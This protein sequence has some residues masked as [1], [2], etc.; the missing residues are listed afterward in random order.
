VDSGGISYL[1]LAELVVERLLPALP[2]GMQLSVATAAEVEAIR[3]LDPAFH[4]EM[5]VLV[6]S[7]ETG[8]SRRVVQ[9]GPYY[10]APP[11]AFDDVERV[12]IALRDIADEACEETHDYYQSDAEIENGTIR[13]WFG[14]VPHGSPEGPWR[15]VVPELQP[16]PLNSLSG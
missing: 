15:D 16:M 7:F 1:R 2:V 11:A 9:L 12:A 5:G 14:I 13:I 8:P 4:Y 6:V 3:G 10:S